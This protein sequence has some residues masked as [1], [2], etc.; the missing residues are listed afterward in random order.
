MNN[1]IRRASLVK[2]PPHP[3]RPEAPASDVAQLSRLRFGPLH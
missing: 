2:K 3:Y 1:G